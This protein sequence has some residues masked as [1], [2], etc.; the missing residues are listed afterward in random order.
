V[1]GALR[2]LSP[3][4]LTTIQDF[5][6]VGYRRLGIPAG[7][8]LDAVSLR[9][10]NLL[11]GNPPDAGA[12]EIVAHGP[13][14]VVDVESVRIA[15]AG[16]RAPI[17][18]IRAATDRRHDLAVGQS[19]TLRRGDVLWVGRL[20]GGATLYLAVEGGFAVE[21]VMGSQS[22]DLRGG[23]GGFMARALQARDALPLARDA[24]SPRGELQLDLTAF[25]TPRAL[26][27]LD[28]PQSDFFSEV[29]RAGFF[30]RAYRVGP[31]W[32]RMGLRLEG[33]PVRHA[34]GH[35]IASDGIVQ[36]SIQIPGDGQP[37]VLS[38]ER[39]T[40]GGYPKIGAV[41]S[42]DLPAL[43]RLGPGASV[44]FERVTLDEA[45][46][47]AGAHAA[48]IERLPALLAPAPDD[49][50]LPARLVAANLVSGVVDAR[51]S[52]G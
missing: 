39:Q 46:A 16:A 41:I 27:A 50:D 32:S 2:I 47:A 45:E 52:L 38:A 23:F 48:L 8:A 14:L 7:G 31:Q 35:D 26:R 12:L 36:G 24:A 3:G 6:R 17:R 13:S 37:I 10:A 22:T 18:V 49:S 43:G 34:R 11:A 1:S 15:L 51:A 5:G 25:A 20:V 4:L 44:R 29:E 21:P 28:G 30:T 9:A 19:I 33:E 40:T 42:A